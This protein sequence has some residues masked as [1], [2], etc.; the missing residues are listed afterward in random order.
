MYDS[1][2]A[3]VRGAIKYFKMYSSG[4]NTFEHVKFD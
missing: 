1:S 3:I 2:W 4:D